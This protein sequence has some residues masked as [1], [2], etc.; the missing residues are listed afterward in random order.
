MGCGVTKAQE[1]LNSGIL[2]KNGIAYPAGKG[3][4][5]NREKLD[6]FLAENP[7]AFKGKLKKDCSQRDFVASLRHPQPPAAGCANKKEKGPSEQAQGPF[8]FLLAVGGGFEPPV[9]LPVRQFSK[10]VV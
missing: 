4:R 3:W 2:Q 7:Y 1:I 5:I 8:S 6:K 10:L 9:R